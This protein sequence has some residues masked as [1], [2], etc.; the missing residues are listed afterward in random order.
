MVLV[1][2]ISRKGKGWNYRFR[3]ATARR[4]GQ[5]TR[6]DA[7]RL[8]DFGE[9]TRRA[10]EELGLRLKSTAPSKSSADYSAERRNPKYLKALLASCENI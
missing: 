1:E 5:R 6:C 10:I 2:G 9:I 4:S 7:L 3:S 8:A